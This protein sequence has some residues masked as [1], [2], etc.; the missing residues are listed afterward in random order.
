MAHNNISDLL[1]YCPNGYNCYLHDRKQSFLLSFLDD[2][3]KKPYYCYYYCNLQGGRGHRF[4]KLRFF[5][6]LLQKTKN[7]PTGFFSTVLLS[8]TE[9]RGV[10]TK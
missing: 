7:M 10:S 9:E 2:K 8:S 4:L 1:V 5:N 3:G 6:P